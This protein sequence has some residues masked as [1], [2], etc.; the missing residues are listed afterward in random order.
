MWMKNEESNRGRGE[1]RGGPGV[2]AYAKKARLHVR[3]IA[4]FLF[5]VVPVGAHLDH[6][7]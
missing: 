7:M 5:I 2:K 4:A 6:G 1:F 3:S